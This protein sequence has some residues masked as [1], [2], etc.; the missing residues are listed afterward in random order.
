[1]LCYILF[2]PVFHKFSS[3]AL[4]N[5]CSMLFIV[6]P[7]FSIPSS[8]FK[9]YNLLR[10]IPLLLIETYLGLHCPMVLISE[11]SHTLTT[12]KLTWLLWESDLVLLFLDNFIIKWQRESPL[13]L[14]ESDSYPKVWL[15]VTSVF[16]FTAKRN[17]G[18][19]TDPLPVRL[20]YILFLCLHLSNL[21]LQ[22]LPIKFIQ[23]Y[24]N[25]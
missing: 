3:F 15:K 4:K 11:I 8:I 5:S 1:V 25:C 21:L 12:F 20:L 6:K 18:V 2:F 24:N 7:P 10:S 22:Q 23:T 13:W 17:Y 19:I 14:T 9:V 16:S